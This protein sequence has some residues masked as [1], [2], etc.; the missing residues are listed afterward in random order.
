M[1][2]DTEARGISCSMWHTVGCADWWTA[3]P[4]RHTATGLRFVPSFSPL[5]FCCV[6]LFHHARWTVHTSRPHAQQMVWNGSHPYCAHKGGMGWD[7]VG[8]NDFGDCSK[9]RT[10]VCEG[11]DFAACNLCKK[12]CKHSDQ[13]CHRC[14]NE[15]G[16]ACFKSD[17]EDACGFMTT[18][19]PVGNFSIPKVYTPAGLF[20][21]YAFGESRTCCFATCVCNG[22]ACSRTC[23]GRVEP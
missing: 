17:C 4:V 5:V 16:R 12:S 21:D 22:S 2:F 7:G 20:V 9:D 3:A 18:G 13:E 1:H 6:L 14:R 19:Y 8:E 10:C 15:E 11:V 23:Q